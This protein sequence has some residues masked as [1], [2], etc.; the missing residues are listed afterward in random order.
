[1]GLKSMFKQ[2]HV[3][4]KLDCLNKKYI[5]DIHFLSSLITEENKLIVH[6]WFKRPN[7]YIFVQI[8]ECPFF[9]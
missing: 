4:W 5:F 8:K 9:L 2:A 1:M 6:K 7:M 3:A